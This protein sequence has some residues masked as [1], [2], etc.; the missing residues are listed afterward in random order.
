MTADVFLIVISL[1]CLLSGIAGCFIPAIPGP[2]LSYCGLVALNCTHQ[3]HFST[4]FMMVTLLLVVLIQLLD[5]FIPMLGTKLS[6]GTQWG[7]YGSLA[8]TIVGLLFLPWGL[9]LGP[10]VGAF[11]GELLGGNDV[12]TSLRSGIGSFVGFLAGTFVKFIFCISLFIYS[13]IELFF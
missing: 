13:C 5:Y 11:I 1:L 7:N 3:A 9:L 4:T 8:G 12:R 2:P 6:G 10:F